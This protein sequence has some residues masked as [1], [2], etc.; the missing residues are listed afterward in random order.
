MTELQFAEGVLDRLRARGGKQY[1]ER[2][3]LFVLAAIEFLQA[4]LDVRRHVTAQELAVACR[5]FAVAQYGLMAQS[6]LAHWNVSAT[7]DW[8]RIVYALVELGLLVTQPG[9][10]EEDFS[11]VYHFDDA[12]V[13][14]Y[15]WKGVGRA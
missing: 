1:D 8:G 14:E 7:A 15:E 2:A 9:D 11:D 3:Y 4:R 5:D 10:R 12:F 6:V 13:D